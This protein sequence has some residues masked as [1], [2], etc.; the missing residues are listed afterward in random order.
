MILKNSTA[1]PRKFLMVQD[2]TGANP[3][4]GGK[5]GLTT[6]TVQLHKGTAGVGGSSV[7]AT[8]SGA[9]NGTTMFELDGPTNLPGLYQ[10]NLTAAD[11]SLNGDLVIN[12]SAAGAD[13]TTLIDQVQTNV[14]NDVVVTSGRVSVTSNLQQNQPFTALFFMTQLGTTNAL[15]G[16]TVTGQRTFGSGFTGV[17]GTIA[18]VGGP[19]NG[20][21]WYVFSGAANDSNTGGASAG[22]KMSA[23]G[24]NDTDFSL[25]FQP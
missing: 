13:P 6:I 22:F 16:L 24:A 15:P 4:I 18:E 25:W 19:N 1:Y 10:I 17:T 3:H 8:N 21:G 11:T 9:V 14:F 12:F 7:A 20:G 5:T 2:S 23:S